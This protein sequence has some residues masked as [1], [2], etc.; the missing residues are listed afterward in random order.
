[1]KKKVKKNKKKVHFEVLILEMALRIYRNISNLKTH[2]KKKLESRINVKEKNRSF[3][4]KLTQDS[5]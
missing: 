1:V 4:A 5:R 3:F 2:Q